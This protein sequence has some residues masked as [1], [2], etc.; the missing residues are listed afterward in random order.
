MKIKRL[1][2]YITKYDSIEVASYVIDMLA[3]QNIRYATIDDGIPMIHRVLMDICPFRIV[4][5]IMLHFLRHELRR[6][7]LTEKRMNEFIDCF[8]YRCSGCLENQ[9]N[10]LAHM[11]PGGCLY[12]EK[13]GF[14]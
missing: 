14:Y 13:N 6:G 8:G 3:E 5:K 4:T 1:P 10:Q 11:E 9:P 12:C 2:Y 7:R